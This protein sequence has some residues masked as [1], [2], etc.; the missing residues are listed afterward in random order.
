MAKMV[1]KDPLGIWPT[2]L[3]ALQWTAAERHIL[4]MARRVLS[5]AGDTLPEP[6]AFEC[7]L[8]ESALDELGIPEAK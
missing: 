8:A 5:Q 2:P 7:K 4:E 3:E 1:T 6:Y